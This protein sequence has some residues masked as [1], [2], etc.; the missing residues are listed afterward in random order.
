MLLGNLQTSQWGEKQED[1]YFE[2]GAELLPNTNMVM[3]QEEKM[4]PI[5]GSDT[6]LDKYQRR[7]MEIST[8]K[9]TLRV[10]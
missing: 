8:G 3:G 4:E 2:V 9:K 7:Q 1:I 5:Q 10:R 6:H